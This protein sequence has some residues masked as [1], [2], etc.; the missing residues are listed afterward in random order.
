MKATSAAAIFG[1]ALLT[2]GAPALAQMSSYQEGPIHLDSAHV[3][4]LIDE[5]TMTQDGGFV[6]VAFTN[7]RSVP[8]TDVVFAVVNRH[9]ATLETI[10]DRGTFSPGVEVD[11]TL[12]TLV[13]A[14]GVH[15]AV[16]RVRFADGSSWVRRA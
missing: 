13:S 4:P 5:G 10:H 12:S 11:H 2:A 16:A 1:A 3:A 7:E 15:L 8:A 14:R 6:R 9:G